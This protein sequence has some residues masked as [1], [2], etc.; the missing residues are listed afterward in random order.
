MPL[1]H[2]GIEFQQSLGNP[3]QQ[4]CLVVLEPVHL[5]DGIARFHG[6]DN[7]LALWVAG[8]EPGSLDVDLDA[9]GFSEAHPLEQRTAAAHQVLLYRRAQPEEPLSRL[10]RSLR[11]VEKTRPI[12]ELD[13]VAQGVLAREDFHASNA[14]P[15]LP[16]L[17]S[18][19]EEPGPKRVLFRADHP[20]VA[21]VKPHPVPAE[22]L[23]GDDAR[24]RVVTVEQLR[25]L[26]EGDG[27][28]WRATVIHGLSVPFAFG[29]SRAAGGTVSWWR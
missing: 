25:G 10:L 27:G 17:R 15:V 22:P 5:F 20:V 8:I 28:G 21:P 14:A 18:L 9:A 12:R 13:D 26:S 6:D 4:R 19:G 23:D 16:R 2:V 24:Q 29:P 11:G 7:D 1:D 3:C